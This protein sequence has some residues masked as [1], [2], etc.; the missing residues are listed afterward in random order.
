MRAPLPLPISLCQRILKQFGIDSNPPPTLET[1]QD[2]VASYTR[3]L[4]WESASR[5]VRRARYSEPADYALLGE[6]F[7]ESHF[8][9]GAG[10][11]CYESNYAFFGLLLR[12]GYEG[13]L[14]IND[15]GASIGCHSAIVVLLDGRKFLV[16]VG[17]PLYT[18][19]PIDEAQETRA[20][21][22]VMKYRLSP[23]GGKRYLLQRQSL[24]RVHGFTLHDAPVADAD[25]RAIA[26]HDYRHDGGQFLNE[27][28]IHKVVGEQLWRF[29]SDVRP[30]CLQQFVNGERRD[31]RIG[32]DPAAELAQKFGIARDLL[33]EAIAV[34]EHKP[35]PAPA[36]LNSSS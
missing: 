18:V 6:A 33:A 13:Y 35:R 27:V 31:H 21:C 22:P 4:P 19:I 28:V 12:L 34:V 8:A 1:L 29:H 32:D 11:T 20:E 5:I 9:A 25:Y 36:T 2:L 16:D 23:Q 10:G 3:R 30:Y 7:W 15:M 24:A 14:T 17:F 26:I